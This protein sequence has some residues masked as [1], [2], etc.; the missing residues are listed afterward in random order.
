MDALAAT[1]DLYFEL[2]DAPISDP[3]NVQRW[4]SSPTWTTAHRSINAILYDIF[5]GAWVY[6]L[7][8]PH[9]Y[10]RERVDVLYVAGNTAVLAKGP[11]EST[12]TVTDGAAELFGAEFGNDK[13][14]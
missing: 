2:H 7:T 3:G 10:R 11:K 8:E 1:I 4:R 5:G 9:T 14:R 13:N 6:V 12:P